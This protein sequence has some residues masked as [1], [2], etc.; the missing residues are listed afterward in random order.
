MFGSFRALFRAPDRKHRKPGLDLIRGIAVGMV[1]LGHAWPAAFPSAGI[2]GVVIFFTLSGYLITGLLQKDLRTQGRIRYGRFY[3]HRAFRLIPALIVVLIAFAIVESVWNVLGSRDEI[4]RTVIVGL[5][6]TMNLGFFDRGS[7]AMRHLWTLAT[8]E[9]FYIVW[10]A[11]LAFAF[12]KNRVRTILVVSLVGVL[13]LCAATIFLTAPDVHKVYTLPTSWAAAMVIG[14]WA[15]IEERRII[16]WMSRCRRGLVG[17]VALAALLVLG[18]IH[19]GKDMPLTY[20]VI[21]PV[22]AIASVGLIFEY[23]KWD[24]LPSRHLKPLLGLGVVSYAAYLWNYL[25][26]NWMGGARP[27]FAFGAAS[28]VLTVA[29]A[30]A[31]WYLVEQPATNLRIWLE[32]RNA[33]KRPAGAHRLQRKDLEEARE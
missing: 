24:E 2:V 13:A 6:Y 19:D 23:A 33:F 1:L 7:E 18:F 25:I 22:I 5:T 15:K 26:V 12:R 20:L 10:P 29:A 16:E 11:L 31:S 4:L 17:A 9:Q 28:I 32:N 14:C 8:E 30:V 21:G 27:D 3:L